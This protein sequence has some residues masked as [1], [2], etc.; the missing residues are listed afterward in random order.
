VERDDGIDTVM[1]YD[2]IETPQAVDGDNLV[3]AGA[4]KTDNPIHYKRSQYWE[5]RALY[6]EKL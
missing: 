1:H 6:W 3:A 4:N 5:L 2:S